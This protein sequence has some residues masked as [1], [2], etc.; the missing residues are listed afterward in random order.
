M[1]PGDHLRQAVGALDEIQDNGVDQRPRLPFNGPRD[2]T[3]P[4]RLSLRATSAPLSTILE[5]I[6]LD[7]LTVAEVHRW[8]R[9]FNGTV[10]GERK[11]GTNG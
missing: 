7:P 6:T 11:A 9:K 8:K 2:F 1:S 4:N 5:P 3:G 10:H